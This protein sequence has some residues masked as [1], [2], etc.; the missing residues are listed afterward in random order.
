MRRAVVVLLLLIANAVFGSDNAG[1]A[2]APHRVAVPSTVAGQLLEEWLTAY[3]AADREALRKFAATRYTPEAR[4]GRSADAIADGQVESYQGSVGYDLFKIEDSSP[5]Q[6]SVVLRSRGTFTRY[7][8]LLLKLTAADQP[9]LA[10]RT[11]TVLSAPAEERKPAAEFAKELE[12]KFDELTAKDQFSGVVMIAKDGQPLWQKAYGM[13]DREKKTPV[14][15]ETRFRLGSMPKMFT[16]VSIAQLVEAGEAES[17]PTNSPTFCRITR[18]RRSRRRSPCIRLLTH[19][20]GLGN[21]F[22]PEFGEKK[23][24]LGTSAITS[25]SSS[26]SRCNSSPARSGP[27]AT[28]AIS[29]SASSSRSSPAK[30]LRLHPAARLRASRDDELR[31]HA[32]H[33][34]PR[35]CD[36]LHRAS[37][38]RAR[39]EHRDV[40]VSRHVG[41]RR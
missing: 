1:D 41:G 15:L 13:Q 18:T 31:Q 35:I 22:G 21:I 32:K 40:A 8:R 36:R 2:R 38:A 39:A 10:E 34:Q 17:S 25:S 14:N 6:L 29:S 27:T 5:T 11:V 3:N 37:R 7:V 33:R 4:K 12:R 24:T 16:S 19:T 30:L 23:D 28:P 20:S 9:M 26:M